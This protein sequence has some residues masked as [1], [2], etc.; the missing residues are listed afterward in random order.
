MINKIE[1][2]K[3]ILIGE[4]HGT[5]EIPEIISEF[6][7]KFAIGKDFN[8]CLEIPSIEQA[9]LNKFLETGRENLLKSM[10]FF[11][12]TKNSD[13]R[14]SIEYLN[15]IKNIYNLNK[16]HNKEIKVYCIDISEVDSKRNVQEQREEKIA[17]NIIKLLS[18]KV[19][20]VIIGNIH[21]SKNVVKFDNF[22]FKTSGKI[23]FDKIGSNLLSINIWPK[24]GEFFNFSIKRVE[25]YKDMEKN[26][27]FTYL[28]DEV[29]PAT[30]IK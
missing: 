12:Q 25:E 8:L 11:K 3:L 18:N 7:S 10:N 13:G 5:K 20:F 23:I 16:K 17:E 9:N 26:Y 4:L 30:Y 21:A 28:I 27:D 14:N 19:T 15:L 22:S 24:S 29:V 1:G 6:F 2:K